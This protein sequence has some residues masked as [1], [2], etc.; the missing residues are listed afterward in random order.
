M[1]PFASKKLFNSNKINFIK[2]FFSLINFKKKIRRSR[3]IIH[4]IQTMKNY[5]HD[6]G[7]GHG[8]GRL[9]RSG[10]IWNEVKR[11][12]TKLNETK[13]NGRSLSRDVSR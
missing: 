13:C 8:N 1:W 4:R 5:K 6:Q 10:M 12:G 9:K 11:F 7:Q 3:I 2:I